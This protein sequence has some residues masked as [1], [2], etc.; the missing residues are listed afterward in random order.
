MDYQRPDVYFEKINSGEQPIQIQGS[1]TGALIGKSPRGKAFEPMLVTSWSDFIRKFAKGIPMPFIK[2][3][4]LAYSV[5][6]FFQ[7]GG[8]RLYVQRVV[9]SGAKKA[10]GT[11]SPALTGV[12]LKEKEVLPK[13]VNTI[14]FF[15]KDEG[16]WGNELTLEVKTKTGV[17][18]GFDFLV[19]MSGAV[20]ESFVVTNGVDSDYYFKDV[21]NATSNFIEITGEG[22]IAAGTAKFATGVQTYASVND[23]DYKKAITNF[24]L[25]E[26]KINLIAVPG[27]TTDAVI[28]ALVE[29]ADKHGA[30]PIFDSPVGNDRETEIT[31]RKKF[32]GDNGAVYYPNIKVVD[33]LSKQG[34]LKICPPSGHLMGVYARTDRERGVFKVPAGQE[35]IIKGAVAL[36]KPILAE[37]LNELNPLG[38]NCLVSK[39]NRGIVAWG[40]RTISLQPKLRYISD[41][42]L[43]QIIEETAYQ[44]TQWAIFEPNDEDLWERLT[45]SLKGMLHTMF[46]RGWFKGKNA[47]QAYY[48]KCDG[49]LNTQQSIDRGEII[50]EIGYAKKRP[51][52]FVVIRV[53]QKSG[54]ASK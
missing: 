8:N 1:S 9:D 21:I 14:S 2:E 26:E 23:S 13:A 15:A 30:F 54:E 27:I 31:Y 29:Y 10:K 40:G 32:T 18:G 49:D 35:A 22:D 12:S 4:N 24:E 48:V 46:E 44:G 19:K 7:N 25:V 20:V 51:A 38:V 53:V 50:A 34:N 5:Y 41:V 36:E 52:E 28:Q 6:G 33:P 45:T 11:F 37:D 16:D 43:D 42:R 47:E 17:E 39:T 3:D